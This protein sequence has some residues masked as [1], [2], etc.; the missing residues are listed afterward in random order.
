MIGAL[1]VRTNESGTTIVS[2]IDRREH[3]TWAR[4]WAPLDRGQRSSAVRRDAET[5]ASHN[6]NVV[7]EAQQ[8]MNPRLGGDAWY[9]IQ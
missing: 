9:A 5:K 1:D 7:E 4:C 2:S 8:Q 6:R 3:Q